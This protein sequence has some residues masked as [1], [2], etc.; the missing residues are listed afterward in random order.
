LKFI[1]KNTEELLAEI[2]EM[3]DKFIPQGF[4]YV[5]KI[6]RG[7]ITSLSLHLVFDTPELEDYYPTK[8]GVIEE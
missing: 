1:I 4:Y 8:K 2:K 5:D 6:V 3:C 7:G